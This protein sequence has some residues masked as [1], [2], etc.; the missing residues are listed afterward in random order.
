MKC[1]I[2]AIQSQDGTTRDTKLDFPAHFFA[3]FHQHEFFRCFPNCFNTC[4]TS[5]SSMYSFK[6]APFFFLN[7]VFSLMTRTNE[8]KQ[9]RTER[10]DFALFGLNEDGVQTQETPGK[11]KPKSKTKTSQRSRWSTSTDPPS[12]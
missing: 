12:S 11:Q 8:K 7:F 6:E 2:S 3:V 1:I 4:L 5:R 9:E 10:T